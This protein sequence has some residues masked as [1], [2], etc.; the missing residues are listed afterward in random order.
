MLTATGPAPRGSLICQ[1]W[2]PHRCYVSLGH[3]PLVCKSDSNILD[4][5]V[6]RRTKILSSG[7][8]WE[9]AEILQVYKWSFS[10]RIN[11]KLSL[12]LAFEKFSKLTDTKYNTTIQQ[13]A[14]H[15]FDTYY[16]RRWRRENCTSTCQRRGGCQLSLGYLCVFSSPKYPLG[17]ILGLWRWSLM[18]ST[19][20][21]ISSGSL[22]NS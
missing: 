2:E 1:I 21:M 17:S 3:S 22:C 20:S 7:A 18:P 13:K 12:R 11:Y 9:V 19:I 5:L 8:Q 14:T 16:F 15:L 10:P 6:S 4:Q